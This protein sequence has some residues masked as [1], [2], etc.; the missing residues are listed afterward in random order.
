MVWRSVV[1]KLWMT[2]I[3]L[4]S[5]VLALLLLFLL[6]FFNNYHLERIER[7]MSVSNEQLASVLDQY[8]FSEEAIQIAFSMNVDHFDS[9]VVV[10]GQTVY[11]S[12]PSLDPVET[13]KFIEA[14]S[15]L[16]SVQETNKEMAVKRVLPSD[17][18]ESDIYSIV[19]GTP[20]ELNGQKG[21]IYSYQLLTIV[22]ES[23]NLIMKYIFVAGF[24]GFILI[25]I[26]AFFLIIRIT[27]P[28]RVL[29]NRA[30]EIAQGNFG[31][32]IPVG[33]HDE[34]GHL[35]QT[36]NQM[37]NQMKHN[38]TAL[39]QEKEHLS[40]ILS[41]MTGGVIT[42]DRDGNKLITNAPGDEFIQCIS[43]EGK[44]Q[45][46]GAPL[47]LQEMLEETKQTALVQV[48]EVHVQE[49]DWLISMS[50]LYDQNSI[51]GA[52]AVLREITEELRL[53]R[54]R[55][56][57][58]ANVTHELRT[59]LVMLQG[60]SEAIMDDIAESDEEKREMAKIINDE[61]LRIG[62]LVSELLDIARMESGHINL[63][64]RPVKLEAYLHKISGKFSGLAKEK[65]IRI[66]VKLEPI[67]RVFRFDEDRIE[68]VFT[69]LIVNAI[70]H[71]PQG[72]MVEIIQESNENGVKFHVADN[73]SGISK[74]D[75]QFVFDRFY[76]VDKARTRKDTGTGLGLTIVKNIIQ[77]HKGEITVQSELGSGTI[78]TFFLP[79]PEEND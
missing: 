41:S 43:A 72:G 62:R 11:H 61:A 69:N 23:T 47:I 6:Q 40:N 30:H 38:I 73:G 9:V 77:A 2:I 10:E 7:Q 44:V 5:V 35:S 71:T 14:D 67:H 49:R 68:Q 66:I 37:S 1:G 17:E 26:F 59:P 24:I 63:V 45:E 57:F 34:I 13:S 4:F 51:R 3:V 79:T 52:V 21:A 19:V 33:T 65:E 50:P 32:E 56:D 28:L 16:R 22:N 31:Q 75:L 53:E 48:R 60:Y 70:R 8:G 64:I 39:E 74:E 25:T 54:M 76:K 58:I 20:Y 12:D 55:R 15:E 18:R 42:F 27:R 36:F 78:F 29:N 46:A